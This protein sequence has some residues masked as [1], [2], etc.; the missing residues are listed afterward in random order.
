MQPALLIE[1]VEI[2]LG[3]IT[4]NQQATL[5]ASAEAAATPGWGGGISAIAASLR[6]MSAFLRHFQLQN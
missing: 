5:D 4:A 2:G 3:G 1:L 6:R